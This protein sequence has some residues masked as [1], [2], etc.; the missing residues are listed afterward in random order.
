MAKA[1][2]GSKR[3][4]P[5]CGTRYYDLGKEPPVC[6]RCGTEF[7]V[8]TQKAGYQAPPPP[9]EKPEKATKPKPEPRAAD[10]E[11]GDEPAVGGAEETEEFDEDDD[12]FVEEDEPEDEVF[13][14]EPEEK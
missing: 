1:E 7:T 5:S 8:A 9:V 2:W 14:P 10:A 12:D 13:E 4:C 3:E 11:E 6:P